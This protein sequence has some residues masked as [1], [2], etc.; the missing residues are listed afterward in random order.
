MAGWMFE[1]ALPAIV[2]T[3]SPRAWAFTLIGIHE[4]L[5]RFAGAREANQVREELA[6]RLFTM[7][8][9][10]RTDNWR[11]FEDSLTYCNAALS[12]ALIMSGRWIPNAGMM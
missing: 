9:R 1:Q 11:W 7:Y 5:R 6:S 10:N 3:S 12:H 8:Q 4:Y 2:K